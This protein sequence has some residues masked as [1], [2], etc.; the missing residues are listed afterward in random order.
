MRFWV[1]LAVV[2]AAQLYGHCRAGV[3]NDL[4]RRIGDTPTASVSRSMGD[5]QSV[6][7]SV[8]RSVG[9]RPN[10][11]SVH[12]EADP[13]AKANAN[14]VRRPNVPRPIAV[15]PAPALPASGQP[16]MAPAAARKMSDTHEELVPVPTPR[17]AA[18][19]RPT[20]VARS[21]RDTAP[22]SR[23]L[24]D[25]DGAEAIAPRP[26]HDEVMASGTLLASDSVNRTA[27]GPALKPTTPAV[28]AAPPRSEPPTKRQLRDEPGVKRQLRDEAT[29]AIASNAKPVPAQIAAQTPRTTTT[30]DSPKASAASRKLRDLDS[31]SKSDSRPT[32]LANDRIAARPAKPSQ[33]RDD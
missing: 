26:G 4:P 22:A 29:T 19:T 28:A 23:Q 3:A 32:P 21:M 16:R 6:K 7:A 30:L 20:T 18:A 5:R 24:R 2:V 9:D 1:S 10:A 15:R 13:D 11:S 33:L 17:I 12:A 25:R 8:S 27:K 31:E 14:A